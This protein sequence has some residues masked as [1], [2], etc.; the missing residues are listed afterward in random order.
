[1]KSFDDIIA[2]VSDRDMT[3]VYDGISMDNWTRARPDLDNRLMSADE[4]R[5]NLASL[6][7]AA[8]AGMLL[9]RR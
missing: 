3:A 7:F 6:M 4:Q 9:K 1:M 8:A 5:F 2:S